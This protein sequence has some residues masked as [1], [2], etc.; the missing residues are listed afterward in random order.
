MI[1]RLLFAAWVS[2]AALSAA[3]RIG[4]E[5]VMADFGE[6][7]LT[8]IRAAGIQTAFRFTKD[9]FSITIDGKR[10]E[11]A[12]LPE[13][14]RR[15]DER[16]MAFVYK[17][18]GFT[19]TVGYETRPGWNF[20]S[21]G[22]IVECAAPARFKVDDVVVFQSAIDEPI[23]A[24]NVI[25][26]ARP[27][28]GTGDY[29]AFLRMDHSRGLLV[30]AQNP[31]LAFDRDGNRFSLSYKP[32]ME[33]DT[34]WGG[35]ETDLGILAP[36]ELT[37]DTVPE[38]MRPEWQPEPGDAKEGMDLAEI[39]TFTGVVRRF[40][41]YHPSNPLNLMVGWCV[42]DYQIDIAKPEGRT[43]YKRIIDRASELGAEHVLFAPANSEVSRRSMSRDDWKWEYVLWLGLGQKIRR[44]EW[45]PATG[46]IPGSVKEMLDY[47]LTKGVGLLA[48]V[49]PVMGFEQSRE[50]LLG[51]GGR[52]ANLG[53]HA[54]QTFLLKSLEDFYRHTGI[55][56][57]SFDHTFLIYEG[58]SR[59][60]QWWGWRHVMETLRRDIPEIVID[61]RQAYQN[62]GPWSWLAGSY[63]HPTSTDEQPESFNSFPD[64]KLDRVSADRERYTAYWY[65]N[66]EFAPAEIVPGFITHQTPRNDDTGKMPSRTTEFDE[67]LL[68]FRQRDW[69]YL[70]WRY[71]LLSSIAA[72]GWNN[73]INM[74][75]A[76]DPAEFEH[77]AE[78]DR[79]WFRYWI[80]WTDANKDYLRNARPIL[81]QPAMGKVDGVA[82]IVK[83]TGYVFLFNP[84]GRRMTP[85]FKLNDTIGLE[86]RGRYVVE[87]LY[88]LKGRLI[89]KPGLGVWSYGDVVS[90]EMDGGSALV[91]EIRPEERSEEAILYNAPGMARV[92]GATVRLTGVTGEAGTT[93]VLQID[94]P[95]PSRIAAVEIDG[96]TIPVKAT[97]SG[98]IELPVT[99][100]GARFRHYQQVD[101]Y[102]SEFTGGLVTA[103]FRVP[104]R[105]FEQLAARREAWPI[106]WTE[107]DLRSTWLAPERLLLFVQF[108]EPDDRWTATLKIDGL[109]VE[110][111][112]AYASV[113]VNRRNF[114]GFY[115]DVSTLAAD[116]DHRLELETPTGLKPGQFQG[117]FFENVETQYTAPVISGA[118]TL[119]RG[120]KQNP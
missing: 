13:P 32:D 103:T 27:N 8:T 11:S 106:P 71:S 64:L 57:Y 25:A 116:V 72:G 1:A 17:A 110:L 86:R 19:I 112:K 98:L 31:F 66:Y 7:G 91:L 76:R 16:R 12:S 100:A 62:Y 20:V 108:A 38:K 75:P 46:E 97:K 21:K 70:G 44:N 52:R 85:A 48:Y 74:I 45:D 29:G 84:N 102:R 118:E 96:A 109:P 15:N 9:R 26:R 33:W 3:S 22:I 42:N 92:D 120:N 93:E 24:A 101:T 41:L 67:I 60:A 28:L 40:L 14:E 54:F 77:F 117:V 107:E 51:A 95:S 10:Y 87:E 83:D 35:F 69:D 80:D 6:R 61:G 50:W 23:K 5:Q 81:G 59:Y 53:V 82:A 90:R 63:P 88:P 119:R 47:A 105:V 37:G 55:T 114:M 49:Y 43:E 115:A 4:N 36:Y 104:K 79:K 68:P 18:G 34:T 94:A 39:Q 89:G 56:G 99:F 113:R 2:A 78:A 111:K 58:A 65:R 30:T 73:V